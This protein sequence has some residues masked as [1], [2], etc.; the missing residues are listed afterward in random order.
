MPKLTLRERWF[1]RQ[2]KF[3]KLHQLML[4]TKEGAA[5]FNELRVQDASVQAWLGQLQRNTAAAIFSNPKLKAA[6]KKS[7][8]HQ[9]RGKLMNFYESLYKKGS[10]TV[11]DA[12]AAFGMTTEEMKAAIAAH[13]GLIKE[14]QIGDC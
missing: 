14:L 8:G 7:L 3:D 2:K 10:V 12:A 4:R 1:Y 11:E 13:P 6:M 5:R 9:D